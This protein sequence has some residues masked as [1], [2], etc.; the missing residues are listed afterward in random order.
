MINI[1]YYS[2]AIA[3]IS[4]C[5][6]CTDVDRIGNAAVSGAQMIVTKMNA[7]LSAL[8]PLLTPP[9]ASF[10]SIIT[11]ITNYIGFIQGPYTEMVSEVTDL[12]SQISALNAA[13]AARK[14]ELGC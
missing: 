12:T 1:Q 11:W 14:A 13:I 4:A 5:Q 6:T 8:A 7:S 3:A 2:D 9:G 10:G